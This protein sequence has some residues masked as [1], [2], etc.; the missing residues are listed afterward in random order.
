M[1]ETQRRL[2]VKGVAFFASL[3]VV[4][5][6]LHTADEVVRGEIARE[7]APIGGTGVGVLLAFHLWTLYVFGFGWAWQERKLGYGIVPLQ[8]WQLIRQADILHSEC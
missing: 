1:P 4:L 2:T 8:P 7:A 3:T 5:W 6:L